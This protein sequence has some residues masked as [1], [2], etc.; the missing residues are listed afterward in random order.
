MDV[1]HLLL[2]ALAAGGA[3]LA[4]G[5]RDSRDAAREQINYLRGQLGGRTGVDVPRIGSQRP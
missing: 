5:Y 1:F 3:A 4:W 2:A